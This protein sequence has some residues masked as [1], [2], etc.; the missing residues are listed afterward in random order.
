M[1][2]IKN[3]TSWQ[4][5][6]WLW[7][8]KKRMYSISNPIEWNGRKP[9]GKMENNNNNKNNKNANLSKWTSGI[10]VPID[11]RMSRLDNHRITN[12]KFVFG[13]DDERW[14]L[15]WKSTWDIPDQ[16]NCATSHPQPNSEIE[17][18]S[19]WM[20]PPPHIPLLLVLSCRVWHLPEQ[21]YLFNY[22]LFSVFSSIFSSIFLSNRRMK[23]ELLI[24]LC[25]P[26][27]IQCRS[28]KFRYPMFVRRRKFVTSRQPYVFIKACVLFVSWEIICW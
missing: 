24:S 3:E 7:M 16:P 5:Q 9:R 2:W 11:D 22:F 14:C 28:R 12:S 13:K 6:I 26:R 21:F 27:T 18:A 23:V 20:R 25:V 4:Y 10:S 8:K 15:R 17:R 1:S 19:M